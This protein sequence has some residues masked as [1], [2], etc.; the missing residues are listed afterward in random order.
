M[1]ELTL[2]ES[3]SRN[4]ENFYETRIMRQMLLASSH[5]LS[6]SVETLGIGWAPTRLNCSDFVQSQLQKHLEAF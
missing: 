5:S 3:L 2:I 6:F 1:N 4:S